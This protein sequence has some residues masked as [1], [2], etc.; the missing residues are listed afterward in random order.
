VKVECIEGEVA[1]EEVV[2]D[3][4]MEEVVGESVHQQ[5][6][7]SDRRFVLPIANQGGYQV[8]LTVGIDADL[9]GLL[10]VAGQHVG[11]PGTHVSYLNRDRWPGRRCRPRDNL[12]IVPA[13]TMPDP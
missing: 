7:V 1:V 2:G 12:G 5:H 6:G 4:G 10:P 8:T 9:K 3:L 11:L 13:T